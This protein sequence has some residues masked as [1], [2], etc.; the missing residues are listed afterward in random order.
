MTTVTVA[1]KLPNGLIAEFG[2]KRVTF[3]GVNKAPIIG[4]FGKTEGV[5]KEWFDGWMAERV[6]A[7]FQPVIN[8][9]IFADEKEREVI[10][11]AKDK[12]DKKTGFEKVPPK[13]EL[14]SDKS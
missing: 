10:A 4:G 2:G 6:K 9:L 13:A 5:D 12:A 14:S 11:Q 7:G 1:C 8:G 3:N